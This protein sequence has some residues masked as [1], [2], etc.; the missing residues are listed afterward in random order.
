MITASM[1]AAEQSDAE[2]VAQS[3][4]GKRDAFARIVSRY[5]SLICSLAYSATGSLGQS[6]DLAQ[7]TFLTAWKQLASLHEPEKLRGWLCG[8]ARNLINNSLRQ[9][10]R[11]PTYRAEPLDELS[12]SSSSGQW[13]REEAI[14]R[15]EEA[16][17][18]RSLEKIPEIYREPLILFYREH[19]SV[20][21]VAQCLDLSENAVHQRLSRG[22]KM[23]QEEFLAFVSGTL[24]KTAPGKAFTMNV[25]AV[26]P[27]LSA[28]A[29]AATAGTVAAKGGFCAS[30]ISALF[31][32]ILKIFM[33]VAAFLSLGGLLGYKMGSDA[34]GESLQQRNSVARFWKIVVVSL[35]L[36]VLLPILL[37]IPLAILSGSRE[38]FLAAVRIGLDVMFFILAGALLLWIWQRRKSL[39]RISLEPA[40]ESKIKKVGVW[41]V[42]LAMII[43]VSF[44]AL[45]MSDTNGSIQQLSSA[46]AQKIINSPHQDTQYFVMRFHFGSIFHQSTDTFDE[47][48]IRVQD[49][50]NFSKFIAPAD[51]ATLAML[52]AKGINCPTYLQGRDFEIFGWQGKVLMGLLLLIL[53]AGAVFFL[54]VLFRNKSKTPI[55]TKK[56][57]ISIAIMAFVAGIIVSPLVWLNHRKANTVHH[58]GQANSMAQPVLTPERS[59][60]AKQ[61]AQD[62]F[63]AMGKGDWKS[64]DTICPPGFP[65][66]TLLNDQQKNELSGVEIVTLGVPYTKPGY[67]QVWVPYEIRFKSGDTK[68]FNLAIRQD[69]PEHKWYFDGGF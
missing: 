28:T 61:I 53:A 25:L 16:I 14:S 2:L 3:R 60:Q 43:S 66:S 62:F 49:N 19:Q 26:L 8:I 18:W 29:K 1:T 52:A 12:E 64:I 31:Q 56:T 59:A 7:D 24:E 35:M 40:V 34:S 39:R 54:T 6:E 37:F 4:E 33:P 42:A 23:L 45:A 63:S 11:E 30:M 65:M 46:E 22:R 57:A 68:N 41:S 67:P 38:N 55:M 9:Q 50:G 48:W 44:F 15:E 20:E 10:G 69:N 21:A 5:Q 17:L 27:V 58:N 51:Q 47:L 13:P 36:F 32:A